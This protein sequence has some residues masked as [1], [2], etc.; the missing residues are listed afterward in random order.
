MIFAG[1]DLAWQSEKN[2]SAIA[3]GELKNGVLTVCSI[4]SNIYGINQVFEELNS[5]EHLSGISI[6]APLII[7][8]EK[9]QRGCERN[10]SQMYGARNASCH[11]SNTSLYPNAKSVYL[12]ERLIEKGYLH[13]AEKRW[14]IEC[15]PHPAIIEIFLLSE[16]LKYKKGKVSEKKT[17]QI[18]LASLILELNN[19]NAVKLVVADKL[20][21]YFNRS[22][23][24]S[25]AGQSLKNNE[26][27]LDSV[28]CLYIGALYTAG[29]KGQIFGNKDSGYIWVPQCTC[30]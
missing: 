25:L 20:E 26:D 11:T 30:V 22:Y 18:K 14:Q 1:V 10:L 21:K 17:G 7:K 6:D 4:T 28:L 8:N 2:P 19:S 29:F 13:L 9:G 27:I 15:Y 24:D 12:S 23:I 16:R 5:V 3:Y